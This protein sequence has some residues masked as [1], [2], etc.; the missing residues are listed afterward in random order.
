M[1]VKMLLA[2]Q[3]LNLVLK[4]W[5]RHYDGKSVSISVNTGDQLDFVL[6]QGPGGAI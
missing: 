1:Q 3:V 5:T 6:L 2:S 4:T